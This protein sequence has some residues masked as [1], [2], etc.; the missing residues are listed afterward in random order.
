VDR[1]LELVTWPDPSA[2]AGGSGPAPRRPGAPEGPRLGRHDAFLGS[3]PGRPLHRGRR[4]NRWWGPHLGLTD[5]GR[6]PSPVRRGC[7]QQSAGPVPARVSFESRWGHR[8][9]C[10]RQTPLSVWG[11]F[12]GT[13]WEPR[14]PH[15]GHICLRLVVHGIDLLVE[16]GAQRR[17]QMAVDVRIVEMLACPSRDWISL[18]W[19]PWAMSSPAAVCRRSWNLRSPSSPATSRAGSN[20]LRRNTERRTTSV[21]ARG[22]RTPPPEPGPDARCAAPRGSQRAREPDDWCGFSSPPY[23]TSVGPR[24]P[25]ACRRCGAGGAP[26][27]GSPA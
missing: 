12:S 10:A 24:L 21:V 2:P 6:H 1:G 5:H 13:T 15:S 18:G 4:A 14:R 17:P 7:G 27:R 8:S 3:R 16:L 22:T 26:G 19:A 25:P 23:T 11:W 9:V 20:Q